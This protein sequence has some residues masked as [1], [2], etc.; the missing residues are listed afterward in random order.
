MSL[1]CRQWPSISPQEWRRRHVLL[2]DALW[3]MPGLINVLAAGAVSKRV[4]VYH[5]NRT[6][7]ISLSCAAYS[8]TYVKQQ[9]G[10][11]V[12]ILEFMS[13]HEETSGAEGEEERWTGRLFSFITSFIH[14]CS[15]VLLLTSHPP[16]HPFILRRF[17]V[18]WQTFRRDI[19]RQLCLHLHFFRPALSLWSQVSTLVQPVFSW[20]KKKKCESNSEPS[21]CIK[22][23]DRREPKQPR[24][25]QAQTWLLVCIFDWA[26]GDFLLWSSRRF[27]V[28]FWWRCLTSLSAPSPSSGAQM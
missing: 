27:V 11:D 12:I 23:T 6:D 24:D 17:S 8:E 14:V 7:F 19:K 10:I 26:N 1:L 5:G 4:D 2:L 16:C 9:T 3:F 21:R 15:S 28:L 20:K 18:C 25:S 22:P 13:W